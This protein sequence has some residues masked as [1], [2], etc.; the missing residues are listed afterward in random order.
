MMIHANSRTFAVGLPLA[1]SR[2]GERVRRATAG[3]ERRPYLP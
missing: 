3:G 1:G 2:R